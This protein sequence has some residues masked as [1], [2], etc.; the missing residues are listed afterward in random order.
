M[1]SAGEASKGE[2]ILLPMAEL[3]GQIHELE[4][5]MENTTHHNFIAVLK[6]VNK[7]LSCT[8]VNIH[9][10]IFRSRA[11][12]FHASLLRYSTLSKIFKNTLI[13]GKSL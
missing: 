3:A 5:Q 7:Y 2:S 8:I 6:D 9:L 11:H 10:P 13:T 1:D 4:E 12:Q